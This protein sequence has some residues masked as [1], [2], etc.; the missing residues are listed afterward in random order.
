MT[1]QESTSEPAQRDLVSSRQTVG[2]FVGQPAGDA[3]KAVRAAGLRPALERSSGCAEAQIG[4][5]VGQD[6]TAGS[7][8]G[9]NST[10]T[11]LVGAPT[12]NPVGDVGGDTEP[13]VS[14]PARPEP[15]HDESA[16]GTAQRRKPGARRAASAVDGPPAP[17]PPSR[18]ASGR[19]AATPITPGGEPLWESLCEQDMAGDL[20]S[21]ESTDRLRERGEAEFVRDE[22][23]VSAEDLLAGRAGPPNWRRTY[24]RGA[25]RRDGVSHRWLREHRRLSA[26][27]AI[28]IAAWLLVALASVLSTHGDATSGESRSARHAARHRVQAPEVTRRRRFKRE[29][30]APRSRARGAQP[31]RASNATRRPNSEP[32]PVTETVVAPATD[33][34]AVAG[35]E[36]F[37]EQPRG[38]PFSP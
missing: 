2:D 12:P 4:L 11:L 32:R 1:E 31:R 13:G 26:V 24:R 29:C 8:L 9:R 36:A 3:V 34:Q 33:G 25:L 23:V 5:V 27:L 17:N 7:A 30:A 10:V 37:P 20:E 15:S 35:A 22:F 18:S 21:S 14:G 38:G 16:R 19:P 28:A 6:P